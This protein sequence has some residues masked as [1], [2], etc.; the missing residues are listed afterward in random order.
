LVSE[1]F[2]HPKEYSMDVSIIIPTYNRLWSL[3]QAIESCRN[4]KCEVELIVIDDGST[5]DTWEWLAQQQDIVVLQQ[6]HLG[7][8]WAVNKGFSIA[9][10]N[11]I[12]FLDSDDM[13][14]EGSIDEQFTLAEKTNCDIVVSGYC[15][16]DEQGKLLRRQLW[17]HTDDFI[18]Q[19]LGEDDGSHYSAFLFKRLFITDIPHR[20]EFAFRDDRMFILEAAL[21]YPQIAIHPGAALWHRIHHQNRLQASSG[22][23]QI[24][25]N[26]QH[27]HLYKYI[28]GQLQQ[29]KQLTIRR[30]NAALN[31]LWPLCHWIAKYNVDEAAALLQ[32]LYKLKP[33]FV[34]PEKG[35]LNQL[36]KN[37]GFRS[38]ERLLRIRR[39]IKYRR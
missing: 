23:K 37:L 25:Q 18:A 6:P 2:K 17:V 14:A 35:L 5:D 13:L 1:R 32:W 24:V 20:P 16:M 36:Y 19:Q 22:S 7:K 21:K 10:G 34:I 38:T 12:R 11:Y 30:I 31:I 26:Y 8:C 28:I 15:N 4:T 33:D 39:L 3:P 29:K 9:R 27:L